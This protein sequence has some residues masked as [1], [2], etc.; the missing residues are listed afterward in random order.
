[1]QS[2]PSGTWPY[3][4][5]LKYLLSNSEV[6]KE[7]IGQTTN[8]WFMDGSDD[9]NNYGDKDKTNSNPGWVKREELTKASVPI[10]LIS[11]IPLDF[12]NSFKSLPPGVEVYAKLHQTCYFSLYQSQCLFRYH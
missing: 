5:Y 12:A 10:T 8:A 3:M 2:P 1:M 11:D 4:T 9:Y 6:Y 7:T